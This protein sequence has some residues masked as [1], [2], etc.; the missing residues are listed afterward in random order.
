MSKHT[1]RPPKI[2]KNIIETIATAL[3]NGLTRE[4]ASRYVHITYVTF[5]SWLH[6]GEAERNRIE[7]N[8]PEPEPG[9]ARKEKIYLNFLTEI[10]D[11]EI[12]ALIGW[13]DTINKAAKV[14]PNWAF[15]MAT[16]RDPK[17]YRHYQNTGEEDKKGDEAKPFDLPISMIAP[18]FIDDYDDIIARAHTEYLEYGGRGSTKSSFVSLIFIWLIKTFP[19]M[20][21]LAL[22]QVKDTL[23]D[24]VFSQIQWA[25]SELGLDHEFKCTV[26]PLEITY[27]PTGQKIYFRGA[28]EPGKIKSIKPA[29]GYIGGLW[30][31]EL[32]QFHGPEAVRK[33][34]Q[35]AIRGGDIAYIFK[36]WNPPPTMANWVNKYIQ[37]PKETQYQHK[38]TYLELGK[39]AQRW[40]GK[41]FIEEAEHL[42]NV[43]PR[44]Y[45]HEYLGDITEIGGMVFTN[46]QIRKITDDEISQFDHVTWGGDW[47]Y[48]PDPA[49]FGPVH[50]DAAR[51][52]LYI[53]GEYRAWRQ[54]N[55][56]LFG[57]LV[58]NQGLAQDNLLILDSAEPKSIADFQ[59]YSVDGVPVLDK[60]GN[61]VLDKKGVPVMIYGP[62]CR[63]AE[64]GPDSVK[65]SIKWLQGLTAIVIDSERCPYAAEEFTSYE[66]LQDP[67]GNYIS[68][69]PDENNHSIDRVRYATNLTWRK[70][71]R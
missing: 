24:S 9:Y 58:R 50:Y 28:D 57:E 6:R 32:D 66:Y 18:S 3:S 47:G 52:V 41:V 15:R 59:K 17:G 36:T 33:I 38:S 2:N 7:N 13:Q 49:D 35:S 30:F 63:G 62:T 23:R 69:Y 56:D 44:A 37:I 55:A 14:D 70:R 61:Q 45:Q 8:L 39:R 12:E 60:N 21:L 11:A 67:D 53:F 29:L 16:L 64:K 31:E 19:Q 43:N 5:L 10:N 20:N 51:R 65:Y 26:S 71:G 1:G 46:V 34:E 27:I 54:N 68:E 22:R 48:F 40:L 25:I 4:T 42:K